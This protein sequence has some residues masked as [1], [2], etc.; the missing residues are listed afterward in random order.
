[1]VKEQRCE[2]SGDTKWRVSLSK[3]DDAND[4]DCDDVAT[5]WR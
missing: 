3:S 2:E 5:M 4:P 1:M